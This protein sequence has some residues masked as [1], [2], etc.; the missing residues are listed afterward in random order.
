M[1]TEIRTR[2]IGVQCD[3]EPS[4]PVPRSSTPVLEPAVSDMSMEELS[5]SMYEFPESCNEDSPD[6]LQVYIYIYI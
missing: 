1:Q 6:S 3:M 4:L 5:C 2:D